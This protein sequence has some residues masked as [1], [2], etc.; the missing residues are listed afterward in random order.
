M[1]YPDPRYLAADGE[2]SAVFK[3]ADRAPDL[4]RVG[5]SGSVVRYLATGAMTGGDFGL[6][7]WDL[8]GATTAAP[9]AHFHKTFSE[10]FFVLSGK[11]NLFNGSRWVESTA[12]DFMYVP[13]GGIHGFRNEYD[14][15]ASMLILFVPGAPR[16]AYFEALA[17]FGRSGHS[18]TAEELADLYRRHD[19]YMVQLH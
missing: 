17:D 18:P 11:I 1:S 14:E 6:Y 13:P 12:G 7:R 5:D 2:R 16:E 15:P 9:S 10:S 8:P 3:G 4:P 19:Q